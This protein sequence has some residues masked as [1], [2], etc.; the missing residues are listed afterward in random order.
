MREDE[1]EGR[2]GEPDGQEDGRGEPGG[3]RPQPLARED[4]EDAENGRRLGE[5]EGERDRETRPEDAE[6]RGELVEAERAVE[7][8]YVLVGHSPVRDEV[9]SRQLGAGVDLGIAPAP[10]GQR[11]HRDEDEA[12][13][14]DG[15]CVGR[16]D[17]PENGR[18]RPCRPGPDGDAHVPV[19]R[20]APRRTVTCRGATSGI[21]AT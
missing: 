11:D 2:A 8:A 17:K 16:P 20:S 4:V 19:G 6:G 21:P 18:A 9:G 15:N 5:A 14:R 1:V 12:E 3:R 7:V 13:K 10:P